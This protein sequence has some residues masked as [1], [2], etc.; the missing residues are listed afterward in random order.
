M[1]RDTRREVAKA[2]I[3]FTALTVVDP[4]INSIAS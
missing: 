4:M 2:I 1:M 3:D